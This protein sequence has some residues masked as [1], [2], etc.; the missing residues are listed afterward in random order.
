MQVDERDQTRGTPGFLTSTRITGVGT[1]VPTTSYAQQE[2]LDEFRID[3]PRIRSVFL[4]SAIE[5]RG[6]VLPPKDAEGAYRVESQGE[7]LRKHTAHGMAMAREAIAKGL[8]DA[9][10]TLA[11]VGYLCCIT[12]TGLLTPGFSA[13]L[14]KD[15]GIDRH[16][17]RL[18]VVGMGCNAG[19]NG[20]TAVASWA[21]SHPGQLALMVCIEVCSAAYVIDGSMRTSVVN[22]L[23]GDGSA[24]VCVRAGGDDGGAGPELLRFSSCI[25]TEAIDAMRYDWDDEQGKFSFFLDQEVPY[26][27]GA[28]AETALG[29]LLVGTGLDRN[30]ISHWIVH[31][32]G[33]KVIDSVRANLGL[34][35]HDVRHTTGVLRD[36]GNVSSGS[37]LFSYERLRA[38]R[39]TQAGEYGV[40][41]TMGPGSTIEMALVRW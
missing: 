18:D 15:L 21:H 27:V 33:K 2:V 35:R 20:L 41:M 24:A 34:S 9:G 13:L 1:A 28:N 31:S 7:L 3:D 19:L 38:E 36:H 26:V 22:S 11:D 32:G 37:F 25:I 5:R 17:S 23:F 39:C 30:D 40:L 6:L 10:A 8:A 4:Q 12:T 29:R 14:V 16:C